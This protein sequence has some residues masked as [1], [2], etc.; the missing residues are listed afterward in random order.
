MNIHDF[1]RAVE[2]GLAALPEEFRERLA[3]VAVMVEEW[4]DAETFRE[5]ELESGYDLLGLYR[6]W[7]L[8]ERGIDYAGT[9]PDTIHLYRQA[10]LAYCEDTGEVV[11][12]CIVDTVIHEVGHY[13]GLSDEEMEQ[14]EAECEWQARQPPPDGE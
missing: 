14:I 10:I 6:G 12:D 7:P 2:A 1:E 11:V 13:Y 4:P 5:M 3:N 8:P 9:L